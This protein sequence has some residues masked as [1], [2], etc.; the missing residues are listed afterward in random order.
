MKKLIL[1]AAFN[2]LSFG[3]VSYNIARELYKMDVKTSIFPISNNFDFSSFDKIDEDFKKW[4]E[5]STNSRLTTIKRD[6][7]CLSLWHINGSEE[8]I[9]NKSYLYSFY[10]LDNPTF[11]EKNIVDIHDSVIF[12]SKH[13]KSCFENVNCENVHNV[14]LGF[15]EDFHNTNKKYLEGKI[16]F[17]LMGKWEKRKH[18]AKLISAWAKKYGNNPDYQLTCCIVNPFFDEKQMNS[19]VSSTL[20]GQTYGNINFLPRL[21]TNSE[22][23]DFLNAID[24]DI[25]GLSG[26]EGWNL[27]SFNATALGKWSIVLNHTGHKDW[28]N[29]KNCILVKSTGEESAEDGVFFRKDAMFNQGNINSIDED[30]IV[31]KFEEA[32]SKVGKENKEGLR[33]KKQFSYKKTV[34]SILSIINS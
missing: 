7:P 16:H 1:K 8:T 19:I 4:L 14:P 13:A 33:L 15:D 9:G 32:E 22:V 20:Q 29:D 12:S 31:S 34:E 11:S 26:A 25:G 23:N 5:S 27:P 17:G 24:I 10:E 2:S 3:N 6:T 30:L 18:T 28:A 21:K